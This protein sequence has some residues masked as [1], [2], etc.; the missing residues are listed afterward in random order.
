MPY[1]APPGLP[2]SAGASFP[3]TGTLYITGAGNPAN[4]LIYGGFANYGLAFDAN[5]DIRAVISGT[6]KCSVGN[7]FNTYSDAGMLV[8][9]ASKDVKHARDAANVAAQRNGTSAQT[10]RWYNTY[11]DAS[12]GEWAEVT[13]SSNVAYLRAQ[14]NGT[15]TQRN[16]VPVTGTTTVGNLPAAATAGAGARLMVTDSNTTT[17][18]ATVAAGGS[19]IVP[20]V[21]DGTNWKV[22]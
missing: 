15:G 22:G 2:L 14:K 12:N 6:A 5:G 13:W 17:F 11:T 19:N 9:G 21:S 3:L 10:A 20:V 7:D 8:L 4:I 16:L 18:M 1:F